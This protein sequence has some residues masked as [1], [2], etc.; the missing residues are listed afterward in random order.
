MQ[1]LPIYIYAI[2]GLT[3]IAALIIFYLAAH[4]SKGLLAVIAA[5]VVIQSAVG[6]SGFYLAANTGFPPRFPL[7]VIPSLLII[8]LALVTPRGRAFT[9]NLNA[10]GLTILHVVRVPVELVLFWLCM[11]KAVPQLMTFEGQNF[12]IFSGISAPIIYYFGFVQKRLGK[13]ALVG[14]NV[15]CLGLLM[16][17]VFSALLSAPTPFQQF[18]F[19]QPNIAVSYFP[20]V[21]LPSVIVPMVLFA[22]IATLR[23][24]LTKK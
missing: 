22:H 2:F 13:A 18:A 4:R 3:V 7:L 15:L 20:F 9:A 1:T 24:L 10:G 8:S 17:V 14:W 19:E 5:M 11:H 16:N 6:I 23:Q 21:L 12:D